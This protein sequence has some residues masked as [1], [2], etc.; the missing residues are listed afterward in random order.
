[1]D[2][3]PKVLAAAALAGLQALQTQYGGYVGLDAGTVSALFT[4]ATGLIVWM[5][6]DL[7]K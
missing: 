2:A 1:M 7:K 4:A 6:P 5:V 3:L